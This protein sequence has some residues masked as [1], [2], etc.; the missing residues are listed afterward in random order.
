MSNIDTNCKCQSLLDLSKLDPM[1]YRFKL[2][3]DEIL[4]TDKYYILHW[5]GD[6]TIKRTTGNL[7][8][9]REDIHFKV[10]PIFTQKI[11]PNKQYLLSF[12][13]YKNARTGYVLIKEKL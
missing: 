6:Y 7:H 10:I 1:A 8:I 11:D 3:D 12:R 5:S 4:T 9:I 2:S 13:K